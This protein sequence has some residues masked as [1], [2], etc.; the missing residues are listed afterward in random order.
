MSNFRTKAREVYEQGVEER[1]N[2][3]PTGKPLAIYKWWAERSPNAPE[4]EN[5][6]HFWRV[7]AI[8]APLM[9]V[10]EGVERLAQKRGVQIYS[11]LV[12][13]FILGWLVVTVHSITVIAVVVCAV[14]YAATG[15]GTGIYLAI[16]QERI[17]E[18]WRF[19]RTWLK[20]V[21]VLTLPF[22]LVAFG[23]TKLIRWLA[24][25]W[26]EKLSN[27]ILIGLLSLWVLFILGMLVQAIIEN[28]WQ[29]VWIILAVIGSAA[30][31]L[32]AVIGLTTFLSG[33]RAKRK[34][35]NKAAEDAAWEDYFNDRGPKPGT[36]PAREPGAIAR[37]FSGVLDFLI[38]VG[39]VVRVK[40]WKIC[41]IV[42]IEGDKN[43]N[44]A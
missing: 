5:F 16:P 1:G 6:C 35:E 31:I 36:K 14:V 37:F 2:F 18:D 7:V 21:F 28:G 27:A 20:P 33:L 13:L 10:L 17:D 42:E 25:V 15:I 11:L 3:T 26:T 4:R 41:P 19:D 30:L 34:A 12:L 29:A 44:P 43:A 23:A 32:G 24:G 38:L 40:K 22:A 39:Q 9:W 8:W